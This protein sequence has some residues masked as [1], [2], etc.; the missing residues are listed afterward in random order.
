MADKREIIVVIQSENRDGTQ[1]YAMDTL[2]EFKAWVRE[3]TAPSGELDYGDEQPEPLTDE[4]IQLGV[5]YYSE[6]DSYVEG[7]SVWING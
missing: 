3:V 4:D 6:D 2:P 7:H 5:R 1:V